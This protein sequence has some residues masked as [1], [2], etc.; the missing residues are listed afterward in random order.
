MPHPR[1]LRA[2]LALAAGAAA[3]AALLAVTAAAPGRA[4]PLDHPLPAFTATAPGDWINSPPLTLADLRGEVVLL[5]VWTFDCWNCYRSFPWLKAVEARH[6]DN[7][8]RV[9]GIHSPE[10]AHEKVRANIEAK[11]TEFGL[12]HPVMIDNDFTY[13]RALG[14]RYWPTF[15]VVDRQGVIRGRFIGETHA[16]DRNARAMEDLIEELLAE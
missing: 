1:Q 10:F 2:L 8:L 16:G 14:N 12:H 11:V 6:A 5:D 7:G 15:Y 9:V 4:E 13:W 3:G